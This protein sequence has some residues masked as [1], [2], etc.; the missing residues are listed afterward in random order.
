M[1]HFEGFMPF[2][3]NRK[4]AC[5]H[6]TQGRLKNATWQQGNAAQKCKIMQPFLNAKCLHFKLMFY[7]CFF[8]ISKTH[9][10]NINSIFEALWLKNTSGKLFGGPICQNCTFSS[11]PPMEVQPGITSRGWGVKGWLISH[12]KAHIKG[13]KVAHKYSLTTSRHLEIL[14]KQ[15]HP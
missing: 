6:F 12:C 13:V 5:I 7:M 9:L 1:S 14:W 2:F 10:Q 3:S 11:F 8:A 4:Y 15:K